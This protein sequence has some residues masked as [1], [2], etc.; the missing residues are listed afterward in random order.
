MHQWLKITLIC[1]GVAIVCSGVTAWYFISYK[2]AHKDTKKSPDQ[3]ISSEKDST[4][5]QDQPSETSG[6][7]YH[8]VYSATSK[9]GLTWEKDGKMLFDH[10]SVPGAVIRDGIIYLYFVDASGDSD[11][12]SVAISKDLGKTYEKK[13]VVI[14]GMKSI[15]S[16]DPHPELLD[17]GTIK[18]YFLGNFSQIPEME[19]KG[20]KISFYSA[21]ST[22]GINFSQSQV[23][24]QDDTVITD[25]DVFKTGS[26]WRLLASKGMGLDLA[27]STDKGVTFQKDSGFSWSKGGVSDTF[28]YGGTYRTYVC[29]QAIKSATGG[30]KGS[31]IL[32]SG[33]R[34][35]EKDKAVCDPSVIQLPDQT[36]LMFYKV[37]EMSQNQ[38]TPP[39]DQSD[40]QN[41][42]TLPVNR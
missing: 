17:D 22:D 16:V 26:D 4:Q 32:E 27:I 38:I 13:S 29:D 25:P 15:D 28:N 34:I 33:A 18:L 5:K 37:Q 1:L 11:G 9:D 23:V 39:S 8:Q 40:N 10:A 36:Y 21:T 31:L 42:P 6:P 14:D 20:E 7:Y 19:Q 30:D 12:L 41:T 24:Y 35:E 2:D 3:P